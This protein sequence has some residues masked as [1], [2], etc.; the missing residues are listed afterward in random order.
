MCACVVSAEAQTGSSQS[1]KSQSVRVL[2][3]ITQGLGGHQ[4]VYLGTHVCVTNLPAF[5]YRPAKM[6]QLR[7]CL[8]SNLVFQAKFPPGSP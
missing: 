4:A 3:F 5:F 2:L 7:L 8:L 1:Y 6:W